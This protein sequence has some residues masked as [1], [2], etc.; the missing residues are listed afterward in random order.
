MTRYMVLRRYA[1]GGRQELVCTVHTREFAERWRVWVSRPARGIE[2]VIHLIETFD[3]S[4]I[5]REQV[6]A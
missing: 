6:A 4:E 3:F 1:V 5:D 2:G